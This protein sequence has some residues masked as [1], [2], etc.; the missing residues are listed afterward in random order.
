MT[1]P[2][3]VP[4]S[5]R[6]PLSLRALIDDARQGRLKFHILREALLQKSVL[7]LLQQALI[8]FLLTILLI[9][10]KWL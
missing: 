10:G 5:S 6:M 1:F 7:F 3:F 4:S 9:I 2:L 8:F